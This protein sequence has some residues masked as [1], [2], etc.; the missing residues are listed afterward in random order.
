MSA[1]IVGRVEPP[2]WNE[3]SSVRMIVRA[4]GDVNDI[5]AMFLRLSA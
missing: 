2:P 5:A 4:I 3:S 1:S